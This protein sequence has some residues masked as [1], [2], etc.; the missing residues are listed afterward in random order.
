MTYLKAPW[1]AAVPQDMAGL[2]DGNPRNRSF[3]P[4]GGRNF[5]RTPVRHV[6][7]DTCSLRNV[8]VFP[9]IRQPGGRKGVRLTTLLHP[10]RSL[11]ILGALTSNV[12]TPYFMC[13]L[14]IT[15]IILR[16]FTCNNGHYLSV[17][18]VE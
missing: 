5:L 8:S 17:F 15:Q 10:D 13:L 7:A 6:Y 11:L 4:G 2:R 16:P 18:S 9:E 3:V 12:K 14:I 1:A